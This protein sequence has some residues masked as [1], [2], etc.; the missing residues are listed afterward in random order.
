M[1][2]VSGLRGNLIHVY[3]ILFRMYPRTLLKKLLPLYACVYSW[4]SSRATSLFF[5]LLV[6]LHSRAAPSPVGA[7]ARGRAEFD[8][9]ISDI[10]HLLIQY[11]LPNAHWAGVYAGR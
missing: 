8:H 9:D 10:H 11:Q 1:Y 3:T 7:R 5:F 2:P 4:L 6:Y